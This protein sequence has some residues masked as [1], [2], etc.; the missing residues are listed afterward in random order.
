MHQLDSNSECLKLTD[1]AD[2]V[3][4]MSCD[5]LPGYRH[6]PKYRLSFPLSALRYS[7]RS[8]IPGGPI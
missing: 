8:Q 4:L 7:A 2:M 3:A 6:L 5:G 1:V